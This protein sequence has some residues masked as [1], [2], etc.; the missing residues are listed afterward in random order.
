MSAVGHGP[1]AVAQLANMLA[2]KVHRF[3][4]RGLRQPQGLNDSSEKRA[5]QF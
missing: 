5:P 1:A 2:L 3:G 4:Q